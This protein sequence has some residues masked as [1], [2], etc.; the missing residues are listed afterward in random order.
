MYSY[1]AEVLNFLNFMNVFSLEKVLAEMLS[2]VLRLY[3]FYPVTCTG[4]GSESLL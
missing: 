2:S 3:G 1:S 4:V